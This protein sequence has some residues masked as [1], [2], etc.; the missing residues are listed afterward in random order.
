MAGE[1]RENQRVM[2]SKRLIKESLMRLLAKESLHKISIRMLCEEAGVNRSTFYKYYGSQYDVLAEMEADM[3]GSVRCTLEDGGVDGASGEKLEM[4]CA[5]FE[6]HMDSVQALVGNNVD[7]DFPERLFNMP[8]IRQLIL[9]RMG[10]RYDAEEQDYVYAFLVNG[11]YRLLR[12]WLSRDSR[13]SFSEVAHLMED[14]IDRV[15]K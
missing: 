1:R 4:I 6:R 5:Y 9:E 2:L 14:L 7:P 12:E 10:D 3:I 8:Q 15:C 13:K 11:C